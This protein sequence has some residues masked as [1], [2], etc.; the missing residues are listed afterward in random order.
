[1]AENGRLKKFDRVITGLLTSTTVAEAA[2]KSR[3]SERTIYRWLREDK[4]F[5]HDFRQARHRLLGHGAG[6]MAA[7]FGKAISIIEQALDGVEIK[8]AQFLAAKL[9]VETCRAIE[10]DDLSDRVAELET[11]VRERQTGYTDELKQYSEQQLQARLSKLQTESLEHCSIE[12]L[13]G[14]LRYLNRMG[15]NGDD[16][17]DGS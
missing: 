5:Q 14:R 16:S 11:R 13:E 3:V 6:R 10:E 2:Q 7:L 12:Q 17:G 9:T 1:M 8:R 4:D 15:G